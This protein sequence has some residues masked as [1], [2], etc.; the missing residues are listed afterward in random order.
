MKANGM[1]AGR[2]T[3]WA[4]AARRALR[5]AGTV[6]AALMRPTLAAFLAALLVAGP[7]R[8]QDQ[9]QQQQPAPAPQRPGLPTPQ[10]PAQEVYNTPPPTNPP[11]PVSLGSSKYHYTKAPRGFP[12]LIA[13]YRPIP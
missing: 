4:R 6:S 8:A 1:T 9:P 2:S 3:N 11:I 12:N 13:P 7:V 10:T 5:N